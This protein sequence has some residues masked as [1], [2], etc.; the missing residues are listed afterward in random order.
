MGHG[1]LVTDFT[2][3]IDVACIHLWLRTCKM[4][5][6][7]FTLPHED[8]ALQEGSLGDAH[9][10]GGDRVVA[11]FLLLRGMCQLMTTCFMSD[12]TYLARAL[13]T[14][15]QAKQVQSVVSSRIWNRRPLLYKD[16]FFPCMHMR[17]LVES[18]LGRSTRLPHWLDQVSCS[19]SDII[20]FSSENVQVSQRYRYL[21]LHCFD[22]GTMF[23]LA[24][25]T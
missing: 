11:A 21:R 25:P 24:G 3:Y 5:G 13:S 4:S 17:D 18:T 8:Q 23:S 14:H 20:V 1:H 9:Q 2:S 10:G 15:S 6:S 16:T 7:P 12:H 22:C 19:I